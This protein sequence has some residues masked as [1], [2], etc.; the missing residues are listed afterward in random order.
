MDYP[1]L[2][3]IC[4]I[5]DAY[6]TVTIY[7]GTSELLYQGSPSDVAQ[8]QATDSD[9]DIIRNYIVYELEV[10]RSDVLLKVDY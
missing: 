1:K 6:E 5:M 3:D 9:G 7:F 2:Y 10:R 8:G 4:G